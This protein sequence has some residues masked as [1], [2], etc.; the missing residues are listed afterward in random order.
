MKKQLAFFL[1]RA[2]V[3]LSWVHCSE[4][5]SYVAPEDDEEEAEDS[6]V[7]TDDSLNG[8]PPALDDEILECLGNI[9]LSEHFRRFGKELDVEGPKSLEDVYKDGESE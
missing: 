5:E 3:P 8:P 1:A 9:K 4:P 6:A 7:E 2:Q